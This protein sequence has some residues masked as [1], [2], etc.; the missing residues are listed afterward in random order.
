MMSRICLLRAVA[1][2]PPPPPPPSLL[3]PPADG[4]SMVLRGALSDDW[5]TLPSVCSNFTGLVCVCVCVCMCVCVCELVCGCV[6]VC[7]C[8]CNSPIILLFPGDLW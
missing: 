4:T 7:V 6:C 3:V 8:V 2:L 5:D 1:S